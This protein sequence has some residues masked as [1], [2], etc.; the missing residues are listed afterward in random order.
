MNK[1]FELCLFAFLLLGLP[2]LATSASFDCTKA[3]RPAEK[4]VCRDAEL[5]I[6]D[7]KLGQSYKSAM[8]AT[9][10]A[11]KK[12]LAAEQGH[13]IIYTRN[14]CRDASCLKKA[15]LSRSAILERNEKYIIDQ[16]SCEATKGVECIN[17]VVYRDT[18][19]RILSFNQ[20]ILHAKKTG[21]ISSCTQLINLPVGVTGGN[22]SFGGL[23]TLQ[24]GGQ[25][26]AVEICNDDMFGHFEMQSVD[27]LATSKKDVINFIHEECFGG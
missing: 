18:T 19:I 5:S 26:R 14:E 7:S 13:W 2:S 11:G 9:D 10:A 23:C 3:L 17:V 1:V 4:L 12:S 22:S 16:S 21:T 24:D 15:Y 20:S 8:G 6:L 25:S 27:P